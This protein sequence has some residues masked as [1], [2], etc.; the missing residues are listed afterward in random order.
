MKTPAIFLAL[1]FGVSLRLAMAAPPDATPAPVNPP[2]IDVLFWFDTEDYLLPAA[3]DAAKR[4]AQMFTERGIR[5]TFKVVGEKARAL[6]KRGRKDVIEALQKHAIGYHSNLHSVHPTPS[7]YLEEYG[8]LDGMGEFVRREY[9]GA[10]DV[11]RIF[12]VPLLACYGQPGSSWA[13]QAIAALPRIGV[14]PAKQPCYVDEGSHVGLD[15][16]PFWYES[17]INVYHMG[18]NVTRMELHDPSVVDDAK[19]KVSA[20]AAHLAQNGGGLISIFYHPCE[21]VH[22]QFWDGVNFA[23]GRNPPREE[24]KAPPQLPAEETEA[25]FQRF[26]QYIDHI[27]TIPGVRFVTADQLP[28][29]YQDG[30]HFGGVKQEELDELAARIVASG[31]N[32]S[33]T[34]DFQLLNQKAFSVADQFE[35]LTL[36]V[37]RMVKD[38]ALGF[39][40]TTSSLLGPISEPP[41]SRADP[42]LDWPAFRDSVID[43]ADF[44]D[45]QHRIPDRIF[46]G[47]E[48]VPPADYLVALAS[49]YQAYRKTGKIEGVDLGK[50]VSIAAERYIAKD[51]PQLFGGWVIHRTGFRGPRL[52]EFARLQAWTLKPA[53]RA[54]G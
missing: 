48:S 50:G 34:E 7:E 20:I 37:N 2:R 49:A 16:Q 36:A 21:W 39:P 24:W 29:I 46:I 27:R 6:E 28:D 32:A 40:I 9:A 45:K 1:F 22:E 51:T 4:I 25:A 52:M 26:G 3:D 19:A 14:A 11:R 18:H 38:E 5:V 12:N 43:V 41:A 13:P 30:A 44:L 54:P 8:F 53:I 15:E 35:L 17:A 31:R 33:P 47:A 10:E 23:R 42:H